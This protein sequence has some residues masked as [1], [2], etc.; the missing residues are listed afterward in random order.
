MNEYSAQLLQLIVQY[1]LDDR[2]PNPLKQV[3]FMCENSWLHPYTAKAW[4]YKIRPLIDEQHKYGNYL[5]CPAT[6]KE[7]LVN[8]K[9]FDIELGHL[10]EKPDE[11]SQIRQLKK[12]IKQLKEALGQTQA[13]K[14]IADEF[15][16]IAC[17]KLGLDVEEFKKKADTML[18]TEPKGK[19][20]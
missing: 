16:T 6:A 19:D 8:G 18:F 11:V 14:V 10:V 17:E 9:G 20:K 13:E 3:R 12:Q 2:F 15:L 5:P 1:R 4:I 7:L